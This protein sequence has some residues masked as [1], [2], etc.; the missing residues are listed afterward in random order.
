MNLINKLFIT[1]PLISILSYLWYTVIMIDFYSKYRDTDTTIYNKIIGSIVVLFI[2]GSA[3][4]TQV[5]NNGLKAIIYGALVGFVLYGFCN[6]VYLTISKKWDI[7]IFMVDTSWGI[8]M[9][10]FISYL[11]YLFS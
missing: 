2:L 9:S 3:I 8:I 10:S 7:N 5:L 1:I 6:G 11:V 4:A